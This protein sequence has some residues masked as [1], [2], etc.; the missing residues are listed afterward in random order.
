MEFHK[1]QEALRCSK[2]LTD[3]LDEGL[4]FEDGLRKL[5]ETHRSTHTRK[6]SRNFS[7]YQ[8]TQFY[9]LYVLSG[10]DITDAYD[11]LARLWF[12]DTKLSRGTKLISK[13]SF[14]YAI[15]NIKVAMEK[16][17]GSASTWE[18]EYGD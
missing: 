7:D 11:K 3:I 16:K 9:G 15:K 5:D 12:Q 8:K 13:E 10:N 1:N 6:R 2:I 4:S 18:N 17:S 14:R